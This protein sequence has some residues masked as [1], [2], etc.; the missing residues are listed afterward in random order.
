MSQN[1]ILLMYSGG[2]DSTGV[3][4]QLFTNPEFNTRPLIVHHI[5]LQNRELRAEPEAKAVETILDYYAAEYPN[6]EFTYSHNI[7]N[8]LGFASLKSDSF[9]YD[10]DVYSFIAGNICVARKDISQVATG[11]TITDTENGGTNFQRRASRAQQIFAAVFS[12]EKEPRPNY[13]FPM[14][15]FSKEKIWASLP[16]KVRNAAWYCREPAFTAPETA[17]PCQQCVTCKEVAE[18]IQSKQTH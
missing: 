7:F 1:T 13:V 6:R 3:L 14:L 2:I 8:T 9:P 12:L 11:R 15:Y 5:F 18:F 17:Q 10:M 16:E 4:H